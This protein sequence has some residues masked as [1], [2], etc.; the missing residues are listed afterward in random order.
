MDKPVLVFFPH[1]LRQ[2]HGGP[3]SLLYHLKKGLGNSTDVVFLSSLINLE[4]EAI[5][6]VYAAHPN[7][8]L[9]KKLIPMSW[10]I[11]RRVRRWLKEI[12]NPDS[13]VTQSVHPN[14]Y[15]LLHF[16][17][18]IDIWRYRALL[19]NF[20]GKVV[21]T[22]HTPK[23]YHL[24]LIEDVWG[25]TVDAVSKNDLKILQDMEAFAYHKAHH[26]IFP[27]AEAVNAY[28]TLWPA[29]TQLTAGKSVA[30]VPTGVVPSMADAVRSTVRDAMCIPDDAFVVTFAARKLA[31]KGYDLLVS[32]AKMLLPQCEDLYFV[33]IG[34]QNGQPLVDHPR[35]HQTGWTDDPFRYIQTGDL[36]V[37]PNR[38][39]YFDLNVLE[40][41]S[42]GKPL[43]LSNTGG[44]QYFH[45]FG[46]E[47]I[48][49]H[50]P[51]V[52]G[53][54]DGILAGY[55][56]RRRLPIAGQNNKKLYETYFTA[57]RF[58][59]NMLTAYKNFAD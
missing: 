41:L 15:S 29:F 59:Q 46:F 33:I 30:F 50:E 56:N 13:R 31:V 22:P 40:T 35:W 7:L 54:T 17:E 51:T 24:E 23:P 38:Y 12:N 39:T 14:N 52:R 49:F 4:N 1:A 20:S 9:L 8:A 27:C 36:H 55:G 53:L 10:R 47:G 18:P 11:H 3:Y 16:H 6:P 5:D 45:R 44:N 48:A 19:K 25:L 21:F 43:L 34:K 58:A 37:V 2:R 28:P 57:E 32:A 26:F 42:L